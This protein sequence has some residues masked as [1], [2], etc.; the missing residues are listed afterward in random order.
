M[1]A[2]ARVPRGV[3]LSAS[4]HAISRSAAVFGEASEPPVEDQTD[5]RERLAR[6][7]HA[8]QT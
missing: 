5:L 3:R 4:G 8:V 7:V 2:V 1:A 6:L